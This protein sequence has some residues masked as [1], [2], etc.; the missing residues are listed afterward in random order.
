MVTYNKTLF[1]MQAA[2]GIDFRTLSLYRRK[3]VAP[4]IK[5]AIRI[6]DATKGIVGSLE[7]WRENVQ[8]SDTQDK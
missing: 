4:S 3:K 2:T 1:E 8:S 6:K 5:N 7:D